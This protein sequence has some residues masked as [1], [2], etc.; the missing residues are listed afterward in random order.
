[1]F[2]VGRT[3]KKK[4]IGCL[5]CLRAQRRDQRQDLSNLAACLL[6]R[7]ESLGGFDDLGEVVLVLYGFSSRRRH[8][9]FKCDWSSDVCSSDLTVEFSTA[10]GKTRFRK[11][12][13]QIVDDVLIV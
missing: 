13:H 12:D 6:R 5:F 1:M 3:I 7:P 9:R 11:E 4:D 10:K 2:G 8:K